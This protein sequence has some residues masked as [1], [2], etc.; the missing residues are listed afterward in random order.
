MHPN[1]I[2]LAV[3]VF[4]AAIIAESMLGRTKRAGTYR[5][6]CAIADLD[7]GIASQVAEIFLKGLGLAVYTVVYQHRWVTFPE[8]SP[9]PWVIGIVGIDFLYY[10]WHR[11]SHGVNVLWAVHGVH[12][13]SEDM[14]LAVALRQPAFEAIT[15]IPFYLPLALVGVEPWIYVSCYALDLIY[16]FWVHTEL[17]RRH[18]SIELVF[19]TPSAHRVHHGINP[20]YLDKNYAGIFLVW[21]RIF[22]TYEPEVEPPVYGVTHALASYNPLWA[23]VAPFAE[24]ARR[25]QSTQPGK[26]LGILL[27]HPGGDAKPGEVHRAS[28][29]KYHPPSRPR[30]NRYVLAHFILVALGGGAFL[31]IAEKLSILEAILPSAILLASVAALGG[32]MERKRWALSVDVARQGSAAL[33]VGWAVGAR[34]GWAAGSTAALGLGVVFAGLFASFRPEPSSEA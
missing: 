34:F 26:K 7:V 16:Q 14:N 19:N 25:I 29:I 4:F 32:W 6:G 1:L 20:R 11:A 23:N 24:I 30:T 2:A 13:Q 15:I 27:A 28:F 17:T 10:W 33:F 22:G 5:L 12:H 18:P 21:D 3:P 31:S 8:G 9:W